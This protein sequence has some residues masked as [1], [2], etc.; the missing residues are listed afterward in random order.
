MT[1]ETAGRARARFLARR[2]R[3]TVIALA[4]ICSALAGSIAPAAPVAEGGAAAQQLWVK[5]LTHC[6]ESYFYAGSVFDHSGMLSDVGAGNNPSVVEFRGVRFNTVPMRVTDAERLNGVSV[7]DRVTMLAH[8]YR[9]DGGDWEDGPDLQPRNTNDALGLA[10]QSVVS[11]AGEMGDGGSMAFEV[12]QFKGKWMVSRSGSDLSGPLLSSKGFYSFDQLQG[13]AAPKYTCPQLSEKVQATLNAA[14]SAATAAQRETAVQQAWNAPSPTHDPQ[15]GI[16]YLLISSDEAAALQAYSHH[17]PPYPDRAAQASAN[18]EAA[19]AITA[20]FPILP[21]NADWLA[22]GTALWKSQDIDP[23]DPMNGGARRLIV[24]T[25]T[26]GSHAGQLALID[27]ENY[28]ALFNDPGRVWRDDAQRKQSETEARDGDSVLVRDPV[29]GVPY[30]HVTEDELAAITA[31]GQSTNLFP[32][33]Q[34]ERKLSSRF[35][36]DPPNDQWL[37]PGTTFSPILLG[38]ANGSGVTWWYSQFSGKGLALVRVES[39]PHSGEAALIDMRNYSS[40]RHTICLPPAACVTP[41]D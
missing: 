39:G 33:Q 6:G 14:A 20:R 28:G 7:R 22:V 18:M 11:D 41:D 30:V 2:R 3:A 37:A 19:Q 35:T 8:V 15:R 29:R 27:A 10:L 38:R 12:I 31:A 4:A 16:P 5:L 21:T 24:V 34:L 23:V 17:G 36:N 26:S 13:N 25:I 32:A 1:V 40:D 9:V